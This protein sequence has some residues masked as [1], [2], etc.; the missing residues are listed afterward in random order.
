M[1]SWLNSWQEHARLGW[2]ILS[3][4]GTLHFMAKTPAGV[5]GGRLHSPHELEAAIET[6]ATRGFNLYLHLNPVRPCGIKGSR[7]HVTHWRYVL[8]DLDPIDPHAGAARV[9]DLRDRIAPGHNLYTGRGYHW[10]LPVGA[11][12]LT[13]PLHAQRI[14]RSVAAALRHLRDSFDLWRWGIDPC[15]SDLARVVR[16][17]GSVNQKTGERCTFLSLAEET[18]SPAAFLQYD[19]GE[20]PP[21][22]EKVN[23]SRVLEH[24]SKRA[25]GF[26]LHG[27]ATPGRRV[28]AWHTAKMLH[29]LGVGRDEAAALL[30]TGG[31]RCRPP[32]E[33]RD[34]DSRITQIY[35]RS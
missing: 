16:A 7:H 32:I 28:A 12:E 2:R 20:P 5:I 19:P 6:A 1:I 33:P 29:E 35:G 27:V 13:D 26:L 30:H 8:V 22:Q 3:W 11:V 24:L 10:W 14:E 34:I 17:P 4:N 9:A 21:P 18:H 25:R 15:T 23:P 31:N